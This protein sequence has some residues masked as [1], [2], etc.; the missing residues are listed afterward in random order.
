MPVNCRPAFEKTG[1]ERKKDINKLIVSD[2]V[3]FVAIT[4]SHHVR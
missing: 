2:R 1:R 4:V 3:A